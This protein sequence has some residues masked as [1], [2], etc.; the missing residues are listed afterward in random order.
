M[1]SF[2]TRFQERVFI[3]DK[4]TRKM[5]YKF[6]TTA[7]SQVDFMEL[8]KKLKSNV[9]CL[10]DLVTAI[11]VV[12]QNCVQCPQEWQ[13]FCKAISTASPVCALVRPVPDVIELLQKMLQAS[14]LS[15]A[16]SLRLLQH[17]VPVL[18]ILLENMPHHPKD[19]LEPVIHRLIAVSLA[20]FTAP[21]VDSYLEPTQAENSLAYFP[22]LKPLRARRRYTADRSSSKICTKKNSGHPSLLPGIFTLFC[23]HGTYNTH[24]YNK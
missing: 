15:D 7:I 24:N 14:I 6:S 22:Q 17:E 13:E 8:T 3:P 10:V 18:F 16:T 23:Q 12:S 2:Y 1:F 11:K 20:P 9:P 4:T 5:F 19:V 21:A